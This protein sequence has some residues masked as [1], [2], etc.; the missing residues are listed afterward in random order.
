V[1]ESFKN[2]W[3]GGPRT[4]PTVD[5]DQVFAMGGEGDL[6][7]VKKGSGEVVWKKNLKNDLSGQ[8]QPPSIWGYSESPLVDGDQ[9]VCTPGGK[10]GTLAALDRKTG[11]VRWRSKE[12]TDAAAYSSLVVAEFGGV[13]QYVVMTGDSTAGVAAKD[14]SV[15][16]RHERKAKVAAIPTPIVTKNSVFVTSGYDAGCELIKVAA[17]GKEFEATKEYSNFSLVNHH[18]GVVLLDGHLYGH[19]EGRRSK[20]GPGEEAAWVCMDLATGKSDWRSDKFPKGSVVYADQRLY[21]YSEL[22]GA[23]VLVEAS[24]KAW[25]EHGKFKIPKLS[26]LPRPKNQMKGNIWT[27]PVVADG[28]L[29]LRDQELIYCYDVKAR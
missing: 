3:G 21:C 12:L 18:G 4:T 24:P 15:L 8:L 14:G 1:G 9:V 5:G 26:T 10:D 23:V 11:E 7:C 19:S 13:R 6:V 2:G 20:P 22:D 17:K 29:Y 16:W 28:K 27:H 25:V